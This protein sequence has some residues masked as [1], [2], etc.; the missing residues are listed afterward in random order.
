MKKAFGRSMA[1]ILSVVMIFCTSLS[2]AAA[3]VIPA[4]YGNDSANESGSFSAGMGMRNTDDLSELIGQEFSQEQARQ[5][6]SLGNY[7]YSVKVTDNVATDSVQVVQEGTTPEPVISE[8]NVIFGIKSDYFI[9][10]KTIIG[11][12]VH[13]IDSIK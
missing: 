6:E 11:F 7:I 2:A 3:E 10:I 1:W 12:Y 8:Y 4:S 5:Q 9:A 13:P